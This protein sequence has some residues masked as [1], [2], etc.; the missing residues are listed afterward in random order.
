ME[1]FIADHHRKMRVKKEE[2]EAKRKNFEAATSRRYAEMKA[3]LT[4]DRAD[5]HR[6]LH[7]IKKAEYEA[8]V[9]AI[10][11]IK[12]DFSTISANLT[13]QEA[14]EIKLIDLK[15]DGLA[16]QERSEVE[17]W[18]NKTKE[19]WQ[20]IDDQDAKALYLALQQLDENM[21]QTVCRTTSLWLES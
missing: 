6:R 15:I 2:R 13:S 14:E 3:Q 10:A 19:D 18:K 16:E 5:I 7:S 12:S 9:A 8:A 21:S 20:V 17:T 1:N 4:E 11:Q